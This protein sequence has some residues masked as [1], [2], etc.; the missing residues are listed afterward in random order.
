MEIV[1]RQ[2]SAEDGRQRL[3][4]LACILWDC[5]QGGASVSFM[6]SLSKTEAHAYFEKV[7]N[8]V[9]AGERFLFGAFK[10]TQLIGTVQLVLAMPPNQPHRAEVAKLLVRRDCRGLGAGRLLMEAVEAASRDAGRSLLV[11]DTAA[12]GSAAK[13]Y[14]GWDGPV[15]VRSRTT[16]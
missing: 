12:G 13:L 4:D 16:R 14:A 9:A 2:M 3:D 11:L 15:W 6:L 7:L 10:D 5:V 8:E 1:V